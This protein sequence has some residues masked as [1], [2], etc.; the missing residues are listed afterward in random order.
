MHAVRTHVGK[1]RVQL[2]SII[3][4]IFKERQYNANAS[5]GIALPPLV[6]FIALWHCYFTTVSFELHVGK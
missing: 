1:K 2:G 4:W 3:S 5:Q 6:R